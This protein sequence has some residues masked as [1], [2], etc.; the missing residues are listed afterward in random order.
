[1]IKLVT[2]ETIIKTM[3]AIAQEE[4]EE[5]QQPGRLLENLVSRQPAMVDNEQGEEAGNQVGIQAETQGNEQLSEEAEAQESTDDEEEESG[6]QAPHLG[7]VTTRSGRVVTLPS[8]YAAVTKV[9]RLEWEQESADAAI[10]GELR[11]LFL[12]LV[13]LIPLKRH[14]IPKTT[15]ILKSHMFLVNKYLANGE[16]DKVK[17]R[18]VADGRDQDQELYPDKSSPTVAIHSVFTVLGLACQKRWRI[19]VKIDIKGA[20]I[21]TPMTGHQIFMKLDPKITK[22]AREMCPEFDEFIWRDGCLYT[23]LLKAMYGCIQASALWYAYIWKEIEKMGYTTSETDRCV[24]VKQVGDRTFILML[25][26]DDIMAIV[27]EEEAKKLKS[28]LE[29]FFGVVQFEVGDKMSY[30]GM[31]ITIGDQG[32]TVDMTFYARQL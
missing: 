7:V 27:D 4:V 8:R 23:V 32:T 21:Q 17:A 30:L 15:T 29:K 12:E 18:L 25:Y 6:T 19:V 2:S 31:N 10:K 20:F 5:E 24:F 14:Q 9:S 3:N 1:M 22:Y 26:V 16:F 11:Q 28:R 13:A